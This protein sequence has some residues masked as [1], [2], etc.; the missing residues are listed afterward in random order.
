MG[1]PGGFS[2][3]VNSKVRN[4]VFKPFAFGIFQTKN[5]QRKFRFTLLAVA[6]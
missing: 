3:A 5:T 1:F 6:D 2:R 4:F